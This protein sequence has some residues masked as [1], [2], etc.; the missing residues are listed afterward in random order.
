MEFCRF[1]GAQIS[2]RMRFCPKCGKKLLA[3]E[4]I[5]FE[6]RT[7]VNMDSGDLPKGEIIRKIYP[8][9]IEKDISGSAAIAGVLGV[10]GM[11]V[12]YINTKNSY[13]SYLYGTDMEAMVLGIGMFLIIFLM[14]AY[15]Y[16][17]LSK[18]CA[19]VC[20]D[21]VYGMCKAPGS[22]LDIAH[23]FEVRYSEI[24]NITYKNTKITIRTATEQFV[25]AYDVREKEM[26]QNLFANLMIK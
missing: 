16:Y 14:F 23:P 7:R 2:E 15:K 4:S 12:S 20:R 24:R 22:I 9:K 13:Y 10:V 17:G 8:S 26:I 5:G 3:E 19:N 11:L 25:I 1:C 6:K 18:L 21:K